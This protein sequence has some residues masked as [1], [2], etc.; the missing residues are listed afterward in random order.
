MPLKVS[1]PE[2]SV[3][4][5]VP[6][7]LALTVPPFEVYEVPVSVPSWIVPPAMVTVPTVW[8]AAPRSTVP[9]AFTVSGR[10][11]HRVCRCR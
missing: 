4:E 2:E 8:P 11:S 10:M 9:A 6:P 3:S 5:P 1:V 7:K